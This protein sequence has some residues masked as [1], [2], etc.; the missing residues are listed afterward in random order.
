MVEAPNPVR[1]KL[2]IENDTYLG[3][4]QGY[5]PFPY[6]WLVLS[7][8]RA[9]R[10]RDS[11]RDDHFD[12][13]QLPRCLRKHLEDGCT[14]PPYVPTVPARF[15]KI[16]YRVRCMTRVCESS[17]FTLFLLYSEYISLGIYIP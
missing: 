14:V 5:I 7:D 13:P 4:Y 3:N 12:E 16:I 8:I 17:G 2:G 15:V 9:R 11:P 6:K 1:A 10:G